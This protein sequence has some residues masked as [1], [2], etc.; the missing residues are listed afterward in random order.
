MHATADERPTSAGPGYPPGA[1]V[2][3]RDEQWLVRKVTHT[4]HDGWMIEVTGVSSFV[5]GTDAV[6]YDRLDDVRILDPNK[7]ELVPDDSPN[8]RRARL[9]LE[10]VI[11]KTPLP[12]TERGLA[13]TGGGFFGEA[14]PPPR[15]AGEGLARDVPPPPGLIA[16]AGGVRQNPGNGGPAAQ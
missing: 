6:F 14:G 11:R 12:Q 13:L 7:T 3:V 4:R 2:L 1:Q 9:F 5:R 16:A 15:P 8:H 10:A